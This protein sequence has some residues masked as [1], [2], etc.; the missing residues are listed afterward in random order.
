MTTSALELGIDI[1]SVD[2]V[3]QIQSHQ[4]VT[5]ALQ[6][7]GR[8]G[9]TLGATSRG[10]FIPTHVDDRA[11]MLATPP[12]RARETSNRRRYRR[13]ARR[14]RTD[15]V[16]VVAATPGRPMNLFALVRR[17][18]PFTGSR[19]PCSTRCSQCSR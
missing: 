12:P 17:A 7:V 19:D 10:I 15:F 2:L 4:R 11:E 5:S 3:I 16:A 13:S 9:H 1:G 18:Y 8:A 14:T 6:R